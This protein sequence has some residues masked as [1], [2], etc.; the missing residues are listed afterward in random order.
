MTVTFVH[1]DE[2]ETNGNWKLVRRALGLRAFGIKIVDIPPGGQIPEHDE[3]ARDQEEVF[4]ILSGTPA[5]V[6]DAEP[7][8]VP[9]G[10]FARLDP[11]HAYRAQ[12][13]P[14]AREC[15]HH[16]RAPIKW[17]RTDGVEL[18]KLKHSP[19]PLS[20]AVV[21]DPH[22]GSALSRRAEAVA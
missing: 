13:Q 4:L 5:L 15:P 7:H 8:R 11:A 1:R 9:T 22:E 12:R 2:C 17:V 19:L 20:P 18:T 3:L 10:S 16:L 6:V 14:R 21:K